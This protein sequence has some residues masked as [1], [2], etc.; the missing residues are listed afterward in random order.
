MR[1]AI[2]KGNG[3][4][5]ERVAA[6]MPS[7]YDVVSHDETSVMIQGQDN[8]GWTL[9][10]YVLPRLASGCMFGTEVR[11]FVVDSNGIVTVPS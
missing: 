2:I 11:P 5:A 7:N 6:Y 4:T 10:D 9:D 8:A 3:I 1:T